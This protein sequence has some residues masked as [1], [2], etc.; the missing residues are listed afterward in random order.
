MT[1]LGAQRSWCLEE[2]LSPA[3]AEALRRDPSV[4]RPG[5][6]PIA[7]ALCGQNPWFCRFGRPRFDAAENP[8]V[9]MVPLVEEAILETR[10]VTL[11]GQRTLKARIDSSIR[12]PALRSWLTDDRLARMNQGQRATATLLQEKQGEVWEPIE[13]I[14]YVTVLPASAV[15]GFIGVATRLG[16]TAISL[17]EVRARAEQGTATAPPASAAPMTPA[18]MAQLADEFVAM[19]QHIGHA[20]SNAAPLEPAAE[21]IGIAEEQIDFTNSSL[22][23]VFEPVEGSDFGP[24]SPTGASAAPP[25]MRPRAEADHGTMTSALLAGRASP[26]D[27]GKGEG[28]GLIRDAVLIP[29]RSIYPT[30]ADDIR[31]AKMAGVRVVNISLS[32]PAAVAGPLAREISANPDLLFVVAGGNDGLELGPGGALR[33]P[34][35][36]GSLENVIVVGALDAEGRDLLKCE[37]RH[38]S[39]FGAEYVS[40]VAPGAGFHAPGAQNTWVPAEGSSFATPL[41]TAAAVLLGRKGINVPWKMKERLVAT[42]S[43]VEGLDRVAF[44]GLLDIRRALERPDQSLLKVDEDGSYKSVQLD[45]T[46]RVLL[47]WTGGEALFPITD[48]RR[49]VR[50]P[51]GTFR[52]YVHEVRQDLR[53]GQFGRP[54]NQLRRIDEIRPCQGSGI[55]TK[56]GGTTT[57]VPLRQIADFIGRVQ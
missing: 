34:A 16:A 20:P 2:P 49:L 53:F 3:L 15:E 6:L 22:A 37:G 27:T 17:E 55:A 33:V 47:C 7:P 57:R 29:L 25:T 48:L 10:R 1:Y 11:D 38:C 8:V 46:A 13:R 4:F 23:G 24:S 18:D 26:F 30:G 12:S 35:I 44:G 32:L 56:V 36:L 51:D 28:L 52:A 43:S 42:S 40:L 41:V 45:T 21:Y 39:N 19:L 50:L 9:R 54:V 14:R 5:E 31:R